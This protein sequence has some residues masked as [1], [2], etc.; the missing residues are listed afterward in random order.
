MQNHIKY[1]STDLIIPN[2]YQPRKYF[3]DE[4]INELAQSIE[5]YGIVQP[6]SVRLIEEDKYELIAGERRFRAAK[7]IGLD[8]VPAIIIDIDDK[9]SAAIALLE[10][11]QREDLNFIEEAEAYYNLIKQHNYKQEELANII[12]K[13]NQQLQI[14]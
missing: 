3:N 2:T 4:S 13:N 12:G 1:I 11:I 9:D 6:I 5:A 8:K 14:R 10:N 7:K